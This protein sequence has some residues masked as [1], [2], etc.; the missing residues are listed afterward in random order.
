LKDALEALR[1]NLRTFRDERGTEL[2]D[3]PRA[4]LPASDTPAPVRFLPDYDNVVLAYADRSRVIADEHR[5]WVFLKGGRVRATFL[6]DGFVA[7]TWK[8]ER[9]KR[10]A[11][12]VL[13]PFGR[14]A[15]QDRQA[16]AS[17]GKRLIRFLEDDVPKSVVRIAQPQDSSQKSSQ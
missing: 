5:P 8:V 17:E 13:E 7:G 15:K 3:V 12:M 16:L 14:L 1:P 10:A 11:T 6:V 4:P 9:A 2:F